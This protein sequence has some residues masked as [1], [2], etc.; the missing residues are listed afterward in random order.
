MSLAIFNGSPRGS[1]SNSNVITSW[2][3]EEYQDDNKIFFLNKVKQFEVYLKEA[4]TYDDY[5]FVIPLYVDGMPGQVKYFFETMYEYKNQIKGKRVTFIIH[6]GF[7]EG[8]QN[9]ALESYLNRYSDILELRNMGV[10][11]IPGSEGFRLMPPNMTKKKSSIV[12]A[13]GRDF[14]NG[15]AY[16]PEM[17]SKLIDREQTTTFSKFSFKIFSKLGLTNIYWNKSLKK[18]NAYEKRFD[19][20]YSESPFMD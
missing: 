6:S 17:L 9:R 16:D 15:K 1:K 18:N 11:I 13:L 3:L 8:I 2:F 4:I 10:I 20:P 5:L 19:A 14:L 12:T 7:S